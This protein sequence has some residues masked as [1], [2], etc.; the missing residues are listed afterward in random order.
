MAKILIVDDS[1]TLR[2]QL[3]EVIEKAGH[4]V[5]EGHHGK[6][7]LEVA[8]SE[9]D[10][11][12]II[13]DYNMPEFDGIT[14]IQKIKAIDRYKETPTFM[15]TTESTKELMHQGKE[16][17]VMAWIVKPFDDEEI[18]EVIDCVLEEAA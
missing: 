17:G 1:E 11:A 10:I 13:S 8:E 14:M 15:L 9:Q 18:V 12:L 6:H 16:A 3:R 7:G 4:N 2:D 5:V